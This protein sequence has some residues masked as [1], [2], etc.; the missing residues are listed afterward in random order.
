M[1]LEVV[2]VMAVTLMMIQKVLA[3]RVTSGMELVPGWEGLQV[4]Q[5]ILLTMMLTTIFILWVL[6]KKWT[7]IDQETTAAVVH[8]LPL[9]H[10]CLSRVL[11]HLTYC[12]LLLCGLVEYSLIGCDEYDLCSINIALIVGTTLEKN[13]QCLYLGA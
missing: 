12:P 4:E 7:G 2:L 9:D 10:R 11:S 6:V 8:L 3:I 5:N 13:S 1:G